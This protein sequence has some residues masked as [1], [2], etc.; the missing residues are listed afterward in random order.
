LNGQLIVCDFSEEGGT[1]VLSCPEVNGQPDAWREGIF[2]DVSWHPAENLIAYLWDTLGPEGYT[3]SDV[4]VAAPD[5]TVCIHVRAANSSNE[6]PGCD[7]LDIDAISFDDDIAWSCDGEDLLVTA[8]PVGGNSKRGIY[9]IEDVLTSQ[10]SAHVSLLKAG[11][12][13]LGVFEATST[14]SCP[15]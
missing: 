14:S 15:N 8:I 12:S 7:V 6:I 13:P 4:I 1:P 10:G 9:L 5:D 3:D 2:D 11:E